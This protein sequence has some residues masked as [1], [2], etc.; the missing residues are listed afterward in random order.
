VDLAAVVMVPDER[1]FSCEREPRS[2]DLVRSG[3]LRPLCSSLLPILGN[4]ILHSWTKRVHKLGTQNLWVTSSLG[5]E[6]DAYSALHGFY[7]QGI[8]RF[9]IIKLKSY[10][11]MDLTDLLRFHCQTRSTVTEAHDSRGKLGICVLDRPIV[12]KDGNRGQYSIGT[13]VSEHSAYP[14]RGYAKRILSASERQELV[15][16]ALTG[17][18]AMRPLGTEISEHVWVGENVRLADSARLIGPSYI[19]DGTVIRAGA[20]IGPFASVE[21]DC[22][23]D[24]GTTVE[25]STVLPSTYLAPGLFIRQAL[26]E[27]ENLEDLSS[28]VVADLRAACLARRILP[29]APGR[30]SRRQ[31]TTDVF[32]P[33]GNHSCVS[34]S[35][36]AEYRQVQ[37]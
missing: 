9:L 23:V 5:D 27:G 18:C 28:G 11:E 17:A 21:H 19:G 10:A 1:D 13:N 24:C 30:E 29:P 26:V 22:V 4:D 37:P 20:T 8:E 31:S 32:S 12:R 14:F 16:D 35:S 34:V 3:V 7:R 25:R 33:G 2:C 6:D 15:G 36:S